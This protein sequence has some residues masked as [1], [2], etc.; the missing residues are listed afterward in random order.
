MADENIHTSALLRRLAK[1][2]DIGA[3]IR[4]NELII[5]EKPFSEHLNALCEKNQLIPERVIKAA[6]ID[7]T[8]G[9]QL[10]NG[11][12]Q[13]S[14]DKVIQLA[15]GF[16]MSVEETQALLRAADKNQ[17][18]PKIKRDAAIIFCLSRHMDVIETQS[19]LESLGLTILGGNW[20][21]G[22]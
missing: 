22:E 10:F 6:Q 8:Y 21:N 7:R 13:P 19:L 18:Y 4:N 16:G 17:L 15:F 3:F 1:T 12:R 9:H 11:T 14:R 2:Q 20:R 5:A